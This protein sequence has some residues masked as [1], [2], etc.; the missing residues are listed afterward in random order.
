MQWPKT[1]ERPTKIYPTSGYQQ[2][3]THRRNNLCLPYRLSQKMSEI[4]LVQTTFS[5]LKVLESLSQLH[6]TTTRMDLTRRRNLSVE[7]WKLDKWETFVT[8]NILKSRK[9]FK[10]HLQFPKKTLTKVWLVFWIEVSFQKTLI[11]L[12]LLKR[13]HH[14]SNLEVWNFTRRMNNTLEQKSIQK[15][16]ARIPSNSI[17]NHL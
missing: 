17:C 7:S 4:C 9:I 3:K 13:V 12:Q 14:L 2:F 8:R 6:L 16:S 11:W 1:S 5:K 15:N 10:I